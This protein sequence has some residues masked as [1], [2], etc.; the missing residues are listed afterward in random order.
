MFDLC[1]ANIGRE[2]SFGLC[3]SRARRLD[4]VWMTRPPN[5]GWEFLPTPHPEPPAAQYNI[6]DEAADPLHCPYEIVR[7]GGIPSLL[8]AHIT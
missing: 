7:K 2:F 6:Y 3:T 1:L 5:L 8:H 4:T